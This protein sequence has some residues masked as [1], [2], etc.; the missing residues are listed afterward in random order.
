MSVP[1]FEGQY[2]KS[3]EHETL[4]VGGKALASSMQVSPLRVDR[5]HI[6]SDATYVYLSGFL[7]DRTPSLGE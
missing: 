1:L 7:L 5:L 3:A 6:D 2:S 4:V